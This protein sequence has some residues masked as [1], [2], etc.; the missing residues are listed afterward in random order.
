MKPETEKWI[1]LPV[2]KP[3]IYVIKCTFS[4]ILIFTNFFYQVFP[5]YAIFFVATLLFSE[6]ETRNKIRRSGEKLFK[7]EIKVGLI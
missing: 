2:T 6:K 4:P 1:L 5:F 7:L 3:N